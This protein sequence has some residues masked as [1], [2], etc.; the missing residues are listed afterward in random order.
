MNRKIQKECES[1]CEYI[2]PD[3]MGDIKKLLMARARVI[4]VGKFVGE[5]SL[6]ISGIVEY[7]ALY[8]DSEGKLTAI[9]TSSDFSETF[10]VETERYVD[11]AE[12]SRIADLKVRITGPRKIAMKSE[13]EVVLTL[14]EENSFRVAGDAF[15]GEKSIEKCTRVINFASSSFQKS[16]ER[17]YAEVAERLG[18]ADADSVETVAVSATSHVM[19]VK[20]LEGEV[21]IKGEL[22]LVHTQRKS[23][24]ICLLIAQRYILAKRK[25]PCGK[26]FCPFPFQRPEPV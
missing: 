13:V 23:K 9:N 14:S 24:R 4:P 17:E 5:G 18:E 3:Y 10:P 15:D 21:V 16:G 2:L 26:P 7:E 22:C 1:G 19:G 12:E 20:C 11:S 6:E 25:R 8:T